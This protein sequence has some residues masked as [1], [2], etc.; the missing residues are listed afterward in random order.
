MKLL[1]ISIV[2]NNSLGSL[3]KVI[4]VSEDLLFPVLSSSFSFGPKEKKATSDPETKADKSNNIA[5]TTKLIPSSISTFNIARK[6]LAG[7]ISIDSRMVNRRPDRQLNHL[8]IFQLAAVE[9]Q[10]YYTVVA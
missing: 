7:S 8:P 6:Q 2:A 1:A 3:I 4:V 5:R 9:Y 10:H